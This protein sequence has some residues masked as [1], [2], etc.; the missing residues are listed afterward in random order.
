MEKYRK[1]PLSLLQQC[2]KIAVSWQKHKYIFFSLILLMLLSRN[3]NFWALLKGRKEGSFLYFSSSTRSYETTVFKT[4]KVKF[5]KCLLFGILFFIILGVPSPHVDCN[6]I[7]PSLKK[8]IHPKKISTRFS[9]NFRK[10]A[11][12]NLLLIE[13]L[14][15][16]ISII[17]KIDL[18]L[19]SFH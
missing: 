3:G 6:S 9:I 10:I 19:N 7:I 16:K 18:I 8:K 11:I 4:M 12:W 14:L 17:S 15:F 2:S 13:F 5:R 1:L